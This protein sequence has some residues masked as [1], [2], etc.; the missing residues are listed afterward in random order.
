MKQILTAI[1]LL[2]NL[3][4]IHE[5]SAK[6]N[7]LTLPGGDFSALSNTGKATVTEAVSPLTLKLDDGRFVHL[8]GLD[9]PDLDYYTPG[10]YAVT[11]VE[12][13]N[14][15]LKGRTITLYQT[16]SSSAGRIN[17]M[18]HQIAHIVRTDKDVWVQGM[19]LSL[20][21]AR[22]RTTQYNPD[23]AAQ[24][25]ALENTART[26]KEGLWNIPE[27]QIL[28]PEKAADHIGSFQIIE[29][30]VRTVS[31]QK[32][33]LYLNF[34]DNWRDDFTVSITSSNLRNFTTQKITPESWN[35]KNMRVRGW[36]ESYN[37]PHIKLDHPQ[38]IEPLFTP[39]DEPEP[40]PPAAIQD[41]GSALPKFND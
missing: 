20:G 30:R 14:D 27:F 2:T 16:K 6:Q 19:L 36:I 8:T 40:E 24:M 4:F 22:V 38:S 28:T 25:L 26:N 18:N 35:G 39:E 37:G 17:R 5:A 33:T 23:M 3:F 34:G 11:A 10:D 32:N 41:Q 1:L 7:T 12:I 31:R 9:Y 15:F 13:L 29:G 21:L